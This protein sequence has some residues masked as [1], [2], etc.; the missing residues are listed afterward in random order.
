MLEY[1]TIKYKSSS[2]LR[3]KTYQQNSKI[4]HLTGE[5][6]VKSAQ[7]CYKL[8]SFLAFGCIR[9]KLSHLNNYIKRVCYASA[10]KFQ[11]N[12]LPISLA[13]CSLYGWD[14]P[15]TSISTAFVNT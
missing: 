8:C 14:E 10:Q 1:S 11:R 4:A 6:M 2:A 7:N 3:R 13:L 5:R 12:R 15:V 9:F